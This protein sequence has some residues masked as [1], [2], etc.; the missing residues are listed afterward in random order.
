[1]A[2]SVLETG[3]YIG[4]SKTLKCL[5]NYCSLRPETWQMQ[6][7]NGVGKRMRLFKVKVIFDDKAASCE[8]SQD[9]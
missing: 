5:G 6:T 8:R 3:F 4:K 2:R 1:M 9:Q 7:T